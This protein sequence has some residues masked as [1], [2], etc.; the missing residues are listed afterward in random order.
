MSVLRAAVKHHTEAVDKQNTD[1]RQPKDYSITNQRLEL[2]PPEI[3]RIPLTLKLTA[4]HVIPL[5]KQL[6][7][8]QRRQWALVNPV[9]FGN[10]YIRPFDKKWNTETPDFHY[11]MLEYAMYH[12]FVVMHIPIEHAKS[13]L[14]SIVFALWLTYQNRNIRGAIFSNTAR[15]AQAFLRR[16]KWHIQ[17]NELLKEDF[18]SFEQ[19]GVEPDV[20]SKWTEEQIFVKRDRSAQSKDATWQALGVEGAIYGA[21]L[22]VAIFDDIIDMSNSLTER[23]RQRVET[24][25]HEMAESR[26]VEGGK[27]IVLGTLQHEKDLLCSLANNAEYAYLRLSALEEDESQALW[28]DVW[29]IERLLRY[30]RT[31]GTTR[32]RKTMQNDRRARVGRLL[33]PEWLNFYGPNHE[34]QLPPHNELTFYAG[35]DPAIT[36]SPIKAAQRDTDYFALAVLAVHENTQKIF[37]LEVFRARMTLAQQIQ[38]IVQYHRRYKFH[39]IA[40]EANAYQQALVQATFMHDA[41]LPVVAVNTTKNKIARIEALA[42]HFE[43][44]RILIRPEE[45]AFVDEWCNFPDG[46]HDD[47]LDAVDIAFTAIVQSRRRSVPRL[48]RL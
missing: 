30:K 42:A 24:W 31:V 10:W 41:M 26:V 6:P 45:F 34:I 25:Y 46:K 27:I 1:S 2:T 43:A 8:E 15:Q 29:S 48:R 37:V 21:R 18:G 19:G 28:S 39:K 4:Q 38:K 47:T 3:A 9:I 12:D 17:Y 23:T 35:V 36:D 22:D 13:T 14:F 5:R 32:F 16:I 44:K 11:L 20:D 7:V 40:I 33:K